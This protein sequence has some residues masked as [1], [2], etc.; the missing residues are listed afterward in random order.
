M[1]VQLYTQKAP[2]TLL[3]DQFHCV[4]DD[5]GGLRRHGAWNQPGRP[6][7]RDV[8]KY[9]VE[10][11]RPSSLRP[12]LTISSCEPHRSHNR[13]V[14][15]TGTEEPITTHFPE[16][17][18]PGPGPFPARAAHHRRDRD[19]KACSRGI[20]VRRT[21]RTL[22]S[23]PAPPP[24]P[25]PVLHAE[26]RAPTVVVVARNPRVDDVRLRKRHKASRSRRGDVR[27]FWVGVRRPLSSVDGRRLDAHPLLDLLL[28]T[29][30]VAHR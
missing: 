10:R 27:R 30:F 17:G 23:L 15:S 24:S 2:N 21:C 8:G 1:A 6:S 28:K 22:E 7:T 16:P 13:L 9:R 12:W 3:L 4:R 19:G 20:H 29:L 11:R 25:A 5:Q 26:L 14:S 18:R